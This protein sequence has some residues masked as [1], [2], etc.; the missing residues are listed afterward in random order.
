MWPAIPL[1][2]RKEQVGTAFGLMTA[3][4]NIGLAVFPFLNGW[5]RDSTH[6]Y[7][8][9]MLMFASLGF[10]GLVFAILLKRADAREGHV[11]EKP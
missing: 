10:V 11:L 7:T 3:V 1:V 6:S 8:A 2:V 4:Q 9:S 5:L